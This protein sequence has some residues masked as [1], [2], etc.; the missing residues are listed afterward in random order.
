[1]EVLALSFDEAVSKAA[2]Q[3]YEIDCRRGLL[4]DEWDTVSKIYLEE[5]EYLLK[6]TEENYLP[7]FDYP[8]IVLK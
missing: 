5:A 4:S 7:E 1:M 3:N 6:E 2:L 8:H